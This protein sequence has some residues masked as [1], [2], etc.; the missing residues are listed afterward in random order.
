MYT[1]QLF[2]I[3]FTAS[4]QIICYNRI[5]IG[6][7]SHPSGEVFMEVR[8]RIDE[9]IY[10]IGAPLIDTDFFE[11][12]KLQCHHKRTSL[13]DHT[14]GVARIA[15]KICDRC[16]ANHFPIDRRSVILA[17]LC[18]DLGMIGRDEKYTN[19]FVSCQMHPYESALLAA[20]YFPDIDDETLRAIRRHMWPATPLPPLTV[21]EW[22]LI[23]ADKMASLEDVT[24]FNTFRESFPAAMMEHPLTGRIYTAAKG[25]AR[26]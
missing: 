9:E 19:G 2:H 10:K 4:S 7:Y 25:S 12:A 18:H 20:E 8:D 23:Q 3:L 17:A 6:G 16:D 15:V 24:G 11:Q 1:S 13:Y 5:D 14:M 26:Q 22:A 21:E